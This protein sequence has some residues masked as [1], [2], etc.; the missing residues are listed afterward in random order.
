MEQFKK[1]KHLTRE[2]YYQAMIHSQDVI[3]NA[4]FDWR[5][6]LFNKTMSQYLLSDPKR[7]QILGQMEKLMVFIIDKVSKI[8]KAV[9]YTVD[10]NYKYLN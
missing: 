8:K 5:K 10:K 4:G 6:N 3:K 1:G 2:S 7:E 9:N